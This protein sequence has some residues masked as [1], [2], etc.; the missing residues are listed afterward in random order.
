MVGRPAEGRATKMSSSQKK[1]VRN[2]V[3]SW[4]MNVTQLGLEKIAVACRGQP[5]VH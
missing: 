5:E 4:M 2:Q 1:Y 3:E